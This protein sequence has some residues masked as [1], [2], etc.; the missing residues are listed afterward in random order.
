MQQITIKTARAIKLTR[1][2][3]RTGARE[4]TVAEVIKKAYVAIAI[5]ET[6]EVK[7][8]SAAALEV[9]D[10]VIYYVKRNVIFVRNPTAGQRST[11]LRSVNEHIMPLNNAHSTRMPH[12]SII[13]AS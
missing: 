13:R 10:H 7:Q 11:P 9:T 1:Q 3:E 5:E 6:L 12:E 2:I 8:T 4:T